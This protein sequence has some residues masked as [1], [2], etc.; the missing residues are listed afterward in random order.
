MKQQIPKDPTITHLSTNCHGLNVPW[1]SALVFFKYSEYFSR[2]EKILA[3][4]LNGRN[5]DAAGLSPG[6]SSVDDLTAEL[7]LTTS[8]S[9]VNTLSLSPRKSIIFKH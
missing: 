1:C 8:S 6:L 9:L 5:E 4:V 7:V 3:R 2:Y